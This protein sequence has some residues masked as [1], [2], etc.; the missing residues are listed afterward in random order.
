M[1][2]EIAAT[3]ARG[4]A[5]A[6]LTV[7]RVSGATPCPPGTKLLA[8]EDGALTGGLGAT[9]LDS[10]AREDAL[11]L[12]RTGETE[13]VTYHLDPDSG[14]SVGSCGATI[15]IFIEP[16][17]PEPRLLIAGSGYVAQALVR[18]ATPLGWRVALVDDRSEFATAAALPEHTEV[19]V[20][21]IA[22]WLRERRA[23]AMSAIVI[24]TR[25]HRS[26]EE[27]LRAALESGA[28]YIGMIGS[29][30][31]VRAIFR[32]LMRSGTPRVDLERVHAP[33]GLDLGAETPDEIALSIASELLLWRRGGTGQRL[34]DTTSVLAKLT[35]SD[36]AQPDAEE[37]QDDQQATPAAEPSA[38][39]EASAH[40]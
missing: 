27:A 24:V 21:D 29:P 9:S 18:L 10:R 14:E 23:D 13:L 5:V 37:A 33:I 11:R 1:F 16:V 35:A 36:I 7:V 26:D 17:R 39:V 4:E 15:E 25:G 30:S 6:L 38:A 34:R 2:G 12:L 19:A 40:A 22:T 32:R 31:K 3:L 8:H 20:A 28:G